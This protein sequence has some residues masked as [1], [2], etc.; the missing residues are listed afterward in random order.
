M[1]NNKEKLTKEE[2]DIFRLII[3]VK[4][5]SEKAAFYKAHP[6]IWAYSDEQ[7]MWIALEDPQFIPS[8][9]AKYKNPKGAVHKFK[10]ASWYNVIRTS[11]MVRKAIRERTKQLQTSRKALSDFIQYLK[12][13]VVVSMRHLKN[14][15]MEEA[16]SFVAK[17]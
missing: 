16:I 7:L 11:P 5:G 3:E 10:S 2:L 12:L 15:S 17:L 13:K 6:A 1:K 4:N 14:M 9:I 8:A